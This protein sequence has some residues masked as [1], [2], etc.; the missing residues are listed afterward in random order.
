M[1]SPEI[2]SSINRDSISFKQNRVPISS[3]KSSIAKCMEIDYSIPG[4]K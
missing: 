2:L 4:M 3:S 1:L